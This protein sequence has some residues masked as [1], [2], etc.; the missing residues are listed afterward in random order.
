MN[1]FYAQTMRANPN[2]VVDFLER[3][4][5]AERFDACRTAMERF[6]E[7]TPPQPTGDGCVDER[8][9]RKQE[10][11]HGECGLRCLCSAPRRGLPPSSDD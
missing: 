2:D 7:F 1:S 9:N 6:G 5:R 4:A 10:A 8:G 11:G 3:E